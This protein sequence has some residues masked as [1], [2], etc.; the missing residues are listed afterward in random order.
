MNCII[1]GGTSPRFFREKDGWQLVECPNDGLIYVDPQ[2]TVEQLTEFYNSGKYF[3][4]DDH[5]V[6]Y[7]DYIREK[8]FINLGHKPILRKISKYFSKLN[9]KEGAPRKLLDVGAAYGFFVELASKY[10]FEAMG[11]DITREAVDYAKSRN[12]NVVLGKTKELNFPDGSFDV[13]TVLGV[14]EHWYDPKEELSEIRRILKVGGLLVV[15]TLDTGNFLGRGAVKV[16]EHV[17]YF[18][19][20][21]LIRFLSDCGFKTIKTSINCTFFSVE[22]FFFHLFGRF[23]KNDSFGWLEKLLVGLAQKT[24]LDKVPL[25]VIDGQILFICRKE[26]S[27]K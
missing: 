20:R 1:C 2:P 5:G 4:S 25:P 12:V 13:V 24:R 11:N 3:H 27:A 26:G 15:L 18:S 16:P 21:N 8:F 14:I 6:G 10:G 17:F 9:K 22:E 7:K 23:F 19:K